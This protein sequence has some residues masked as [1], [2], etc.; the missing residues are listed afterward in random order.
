MGV[1]CTVGTQCPVNF[2]C[3]DAG[4]LGAPRHRPETRSADGR[5]FDLVN[6]MEALPYSWTL[7]TALRTG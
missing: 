2:H 4:P 1:H 3:E 7:A 5:A 6:G